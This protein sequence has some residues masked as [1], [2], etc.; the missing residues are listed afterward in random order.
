MQSFSRYTD[1]PESGR[2]LALALGNFDGLHA[3]H[4]AVIETAKEAG[5]SGFGIITF[6][7]A[8]KAYFRPNDPPFRIL[9]RARRNTILEDMGAKA[10]FELPFDAQLAGLS[11]EDFA[12]EVIFK[13]L[14]AAH[15]SI[16][17][18][19][20]FGRARMGDAKRMQFLGERYGFTVSIVEKIE[21]LS[22]K[23]S[24]T[25]IRQALRAGDMEKA[26]YML[27]MPWSVTNRIET[28]EKRGRTLGFPTANLTLP[29]DIIHPREGVYAVMVRIGNDAVW[30]KGV[31]NFGRTP[32]TG[33][34]DPL[35]ETFIFDWDK[36]IYGQNLEVNFIS[37]L[38]PE[39]HFDHIEDMV[40]QMYQDADQARSI[41]ANVA[42][43]ADSLKTQ[44]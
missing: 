38:R 1:I 43:P 17:F 2:G 26:A 7:P 30:H 18:D 3:G 24:S 22:D 35:L 37:F 19:Y 11:D 31:A 32:T 20:R 15:I 10:V 4:K 21:T 34:R 5:H 28:G 13:G 9:S 8:P 25:L 33:L 39:L 36:D 42:K 27:G 29:K 44:S 14:G 6:D 23:A 16:G 40:T 12:R 41:L